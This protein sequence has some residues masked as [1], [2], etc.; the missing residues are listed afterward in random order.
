MLGYEAVRAAI[1]AHPTMLWVIVRLLAR[2]LRNTDESLADAV[3]L[4]VPARTAKRLLEIAGDADE[5]RL[6]M[7]QEDLAG[8][9]GA[10]RERVN[11]ALSLFDAAGVD[12]G[13]GA[14]PLPHPRP[15]GP[16]RAR[17]AL[18]V[19][20]AERHSG[21]RTRARGA[22]RRRRRRAGA[23]RAPGRA[24]TRARRRRTTTTSQSGRSA[25]AARSASMSAAGVNGSLP[26][27]IAS[28][29][30]TS[31]MVSSGRRVLRTDPVLG[32]TDHPVEGDG[33]IEAAGRGRLQH[34]HATHAEAEHRDLAHV[35]VHDEVVGGGLEVTELQLVVELA[36]RS[37]CA[38]RCRCRRA[39]R[40]A[41]AAKGS[42]EHTAKPWVASRR[43]RSSNNGRT[44]MMSGCTTS[45]LWG[46]PSGRAWIGVDGGAVGT[47]QRDVLDV[48]LVGCQC[49]ALPSRRTAPGSRS[50]R[51]GTGRP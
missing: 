49:S 6:P 23:R 37:P 14:Q 22:T 5:F 46:M 40:P 25:H 44:P 21:C 18:A 28:V 3:F 42:G 47:L 2:R 10:G 41:R 24:R 30:H 48:D 38:L 19:S 12:R 39:P 32:W 15:P 7:T 50:R 16:A 36:S 9:V 4:D 43:D 51:A 35:V 33:A 27:K 11:K 20:R 17:H 8:L 26:P 34:L 45:P 31:A 13:R 1:D 29:G